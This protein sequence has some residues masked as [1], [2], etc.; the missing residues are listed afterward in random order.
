MTEKYKKISKFLKL[1]TVIMF[2]AG[3][4][5]F[6]VYPLA[7]RHITVKMYTNQGIYEKFVLNDEIGT[8]I[9]STWELATKEPL[10]IKEI[11]L[12]GTFKSI[13]IK[14]IFG[15]EIPMY[16]EN[17]EG[18]VNGAKYCFNNDENVV[19][20]ETNEEFADVLDKY[21]DDYSW[22]RMAAIL[23][24]GLM[25]SLILVAIVS[26]DN[27]KENE[28]TNHS[29]ISETSRFFKDVKKY[30]E[31]MIYAAKSDMKA[32]VANSY[33]NRLW[34]LLEPLF[35]MLVYVIVFGGFLG[36]SIEHFALYVFSALIMWN[37]FCRTI[38][39][40]VQMMRNNRDVLSKVYVPKFVPLLTMMM[41]NAYKLMFS[42]II[43][44][45]MMV[46]SGVSVGVGL[47]GALLAYLMMAAFSFGVGM[48]LLH[49]G[50]YVDDLAYAVSILLNVMMF[51][52][53]IFYDAP[54]TLMEP[55]NSMVMCLNPTALFVDTMRQGLL[56]NNLANVPLVLIWLG[57]SLVLSYAGIHVVYKNENSYAK[58]I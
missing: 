12:F 40:S 7:P 38:N 58:V 50:V 39:A 35:N 2:I 1:V 10:E 6:V 54:T 49:Y 31:Y 51:I 25:C 24:W 29:F 45:P 13:R 5:F 28:L 48:L 27:A 3:S 47:I 20:F 8:P 16:I 15:S 17:P 32:E 23:L 26:R 33:L 42:M 56:Y 30:K 14:T 41:L 9:G 18:T 21:S 22:D 57:I 11:R 44:I 46:I 37:Y 53:G 55:I 34:W 43:L 52:S 36:G 19:S 4:I